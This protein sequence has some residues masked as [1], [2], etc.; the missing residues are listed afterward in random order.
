MREEYES[1]PPLAERQWEYIQ[2]SADSVVI[3]PSDRPSLL[4]R[5]QNR[6]YSPSYSSLSRDLE[7]GRMKLSTL[8]LDDQ[9]RVLDRITRRL[10]FIREMESHPASRWF[11]ERQICGFDM[12]LAQHYG[13]PTGYIDL[14]ESFDVACF[15]AT[16]RFADGRGWQPCADGVGVIYCLPLGG[17]PIR[18]DVLQPIGLQVFPRP[19]EQWGW[20][21]VTGMGVDFES[22]PRLG[23]FEFT[24]NLTVSEYF[25]R[26]FKHGADLFPADAMADVAEE[27]ME[28]AILPGDL[29]ATAVRDLCAARE[30]FASPGH[31][32]LNALNTTLGVRGGAC[33]PLLGEKTL[34][35]LEGQWKGHQDS[36][37]KGVGFRLVRT[38]RG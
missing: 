28:S 33:P 37:F 20:V 10:W 35:T 13:I 21:L 8:A 23:I 29:L 12:A 9:A 32:I 17:I 1:V 38:R 19:R 2:R 26:K 18:P 22:L 4:F 36:F 6:R 15:F 5:G 30:G 25:W 34:A 14:S 7:Q 31:E 16:C 3:L 24:Q 11:A 27:I